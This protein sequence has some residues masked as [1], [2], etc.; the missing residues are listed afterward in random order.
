MESSKFSLNEKSKFEIFS[1]V[2][3]Y[4]LMNQ[5]EPF[6]NSIVSKIEKGQNGYAGWKNPEGLKRYLKWAQRDWDFERKFHRIEFAEINDHL[7][8]ILSKCSEYI[9]NKKIYIYIFPTL[10]VF[11]I[12]KMKGVSGMRIWK[13]TIYLDLFPNRNWKEAFGNSLVHEIAHII[14]PYYD[15]NNM[16]IG[17][18]MVLDGIAEHFRDKILGCEKSQWVKALS[19]N[20]IEMLLKELKTNLDSK[21]Q[22]LYSDVFYG[23]GEYPLWTGY[24]MGYYL[25]GKYIDK[26]KKI[27]W[28]RLLKENPKKILEVVL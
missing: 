27:D 9:G 12:D 25:I 6:I 23:T 14:S 8:K 13:D 15:T 21:D 18:G 24:S 2:D 7:K 11:N 4:G 10:S 17:E 3:E 20:K 26:E 1:F 22:K 16:S 28:N 19:K 5:K